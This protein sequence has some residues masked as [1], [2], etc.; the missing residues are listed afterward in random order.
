MEAELSATRY[1]EVPVADSRA[2]WSRI[3][4]ITGEQ[5]DRSKVGN[6]HA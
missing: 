1:A 4:P 2:S 6:T 5:Q 3:M